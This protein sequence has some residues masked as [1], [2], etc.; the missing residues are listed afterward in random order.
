MRNIVKEKNIIV[1]NKIK[2]PKS[3]LRAFGILKNK[4]IDALKLQKQIR[5]EWDKRLMKLETR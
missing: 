4:K 5:K 1:E 2:M 3:L